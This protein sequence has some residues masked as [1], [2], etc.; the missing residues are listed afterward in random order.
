MRSWIIALGIRS[1]QRPYRK[2]RG[3][4]DHFCHT[5]AIIGRGTTRMQSTSLTKARSIDHGILQSLPIQH[6]TQIKNRSSFRYC[7]A[8][9]N[10]RSVQNKTNE[11]QQ[12]ME[13]NNIDISALAETWIK[14]EADL[15]QL[16][17]CPQRYKSILVPRKNRT[18]GGLA[19]I[20]KESINVKHNTTYNFKMKKCADFTIT[21]PSVSL[22][23]GIIYRPPEGSILKFSQKLADYLGKTS[24]HQVIC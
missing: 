1:K 3:G 7:G 11:I 15:T 14:V 20:H 17:L 13:E 22:H 18:R 6:Q 19:V 23:I 24:H 8:L 21:S 12:T 2:S 4:K 16:R 5:H 10:C 9:I